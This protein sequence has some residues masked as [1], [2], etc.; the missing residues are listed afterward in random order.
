MFLC[1]ELSPINLNSL[2]LKWAELICTVR[3]LDVQDA[4]TNVESPWYGREVQVR[5]P[6]ITISFDYQRDYAHSP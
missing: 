1:M 3:R 5:G 4:V 2:E 6:S